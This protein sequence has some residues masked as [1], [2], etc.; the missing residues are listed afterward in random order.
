MIPS[1]CRATTDIFR[2]YALVHNVDNAMDNHGICEE[3]YGNRYRE[4]P[5]G[6]RTD[7]AYGSTGDDDTGLR[8]CRRSAVACGK[9]IARAD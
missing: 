9:M 1:S 2:W 7:Y 4:Y 8:T 3:V 6:T 5:N